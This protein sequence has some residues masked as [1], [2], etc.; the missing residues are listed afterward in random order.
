ML[1]PAHFKSDARFL[2]PVIAG[3]YVEGNAAAEE[4]AVAAST[5]FDP[6]CR[7]GETCHAALGL[8]NIISPAAAPISPIRG[9]FIS[10]R[11]AYVPPQKNLPQT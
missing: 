11:T 4:F 7:S 6:G 3:H 2:A 5:Q 10:I 8:V 9:I 1:I